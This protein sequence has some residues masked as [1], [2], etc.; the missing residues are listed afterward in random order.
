ME[1]ARGPL[2][3]GVRMATSVPDVDPQS[4]IE[5]EELA[6]KLIFYDNVNPKDAMIT[7][8]CNY[9]VGGK[10]YRRIAMKVYRKRK[11]AQEAKKAKKMKQE[12]FWSP[13]C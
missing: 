3:Q 12:L 2:G 8:G 7:S 11:Q 5:R 13:I 6:F 4:V 10:K 9:P 1:E